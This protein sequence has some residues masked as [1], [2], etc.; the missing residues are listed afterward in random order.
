MPKLTTVIVDD[1]R[2]AREN[3]SKISSKTGLIDVVAV[4]EN[5]QNALEIIINEQ[6]ELVL[7]DIQMP[8]NNGFWLADKLH[9][10]KTK[11][12]IIF[13]T[14]FDKYAI[15][16]INYA[17]F[18]FLLK[19][20]SIDNLTEIIK[21]LLL[22]R[23]TNNIIPKLDSLTYF[24]KNEKIKV[25]TKES[26]VVLFINEIIYCEDCGNHSK[27]HMISGRTEIISMQMTQFYNLLPE[28]TFVLINKKT[29]INTNY[30]D[31]YNIKTKI[32]TL[33]D[34]LLRY[35]LKANSTGARLLKKL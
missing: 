27:I 1:E 21:K 8:V 20:V 28:H 32:V 16:A 26:S 19:P 33:S 30:L 13:V 31:N 35:E 14:A 18:D 24:L 23:T 22:N 10:M 25:N 17:A 2:D 11:T 9:K 7:L 12:E 5:A 29:L 34:V 15:E 6:P 4:A 3:I